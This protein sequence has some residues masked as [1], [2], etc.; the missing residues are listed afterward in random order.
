[1]VRRT[2]R[3]S[4][5]TTAGFTLI[6]L[7]LVT[8]IFVILSTVV[9]SSNARF[10]QRVVLQ[11][12]AHDIALS[13]RQAQVYGIAVRG[14]Q[15]ANFSA[16]YGIY[17]QS[18]SPNNYVLFADAVTA[19]GMYSGGETVRSTTIA[20]GY[21]ITDL[22]VEPMGGVAA[23]YCSRTRLDIVFHRPEPDAEIRANGEATLW[24]RAKI[25]VRSDAGHTAYIFVDATGQIY[26]D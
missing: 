19:D 25:E 6:E 23:E 18:T 15:G 20:P 10:G 8:A 26:V 11:N 16:G 3:R 22:C 12:L 2:L 14:F 17:F 5:T 4:I 24:R 9:L 21:A 7:L 13:V 1:M